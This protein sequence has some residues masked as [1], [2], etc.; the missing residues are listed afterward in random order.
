MSTQL[1]SLQ[2]PSSCAYSKS[3]NYKGSEDNKRVNEGKQHLLVDTPNRLW[4]P[5]AHL[6]NQA[7]ETAMVF[8]IGH[9]IWQA[10]ERSDN[11][12]FVK[13]L[14]DWSLDYS[15]DPAFG[16]TIS[17]VL[18]KTRRTQYDFRRVGCIWLLCS[19]IIC[20]RIPPS[21]NK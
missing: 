16:L 17:V 4:M 20:Q 3:A 7:D 12:T 8:R 5:N 1:P 19:C 9:V 2:R 15:S 6:A 18:S 13:A 21:S 14:A 10:Q 11:G